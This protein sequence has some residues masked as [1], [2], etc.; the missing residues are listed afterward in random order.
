MMQMLATRNQ[1]CATFYAIARIVI[2]HMEKK[3]MFKQECPTQQQH[4]YTVE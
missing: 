4:W 1:N 2:I 3:A